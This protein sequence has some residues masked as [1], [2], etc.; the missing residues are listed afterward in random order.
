MGEEFIVVSIMKICNFAYYE[1]PKIPE[2][3][4]IISA[5]FINY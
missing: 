5:N 3:N 4:L 2:G 1:D